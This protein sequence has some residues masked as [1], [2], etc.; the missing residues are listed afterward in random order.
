MMGA[1]VLGVNG[2]QLKEHWATWTES[3]RPLLQTKLR[4]DSLNR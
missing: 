1:V 2:E 3:S 4:M